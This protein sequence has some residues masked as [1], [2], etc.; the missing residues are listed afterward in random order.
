MPVTISGTERV[1]AV[2]DN[3]TIDP[4]AHVQIGDANFGQTETVTISF[5]GANGTLTDPNAVS[6]HSVI[7]GG[8]YIVTG[9]AAQVSADLDALIFHP[10]YQVAPGNTV[11]TGFAIAVTDSPAGLSATD[12]TTS[13]IATAVAPNFALLQQDATNFLLAGTDPAVA[14]AS[15][16][17]P[18]TKLL[19]DLGNFVTHSMTS[20][21]PMCRSP[22]ST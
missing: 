4:F 1:Q 6:D 12:N 15:V 17:G 8:S 19:T 21:V 9:T 16:N 2:N 10:T 20:R 18:L 22:C 3:A 11:T 13:V 7:G 5:I 14:E